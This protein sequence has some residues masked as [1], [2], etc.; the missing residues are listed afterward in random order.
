MVSFRVLLA[1]PGIGLAGSREQRIPSSL[2]AGVLEGVI[3]LSLAPSHHPSP[4]LIPRLALAHLIL[5]SRVPVPGPAREGPGLCRPS[6]SALC[7]CRGLLGAPTKPP[8]FVTLLC[9]LMLPLSTP[10]PGFGPVSLRSSRSLRS[11]SCL[12]L[13]PYQGFLRRCKRSI[14]GP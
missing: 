2:G 3:L 1:P 10:L 11:V 12:A 5:R 4:G 7:R 9:V 8:G 13:S 6:G 14:L